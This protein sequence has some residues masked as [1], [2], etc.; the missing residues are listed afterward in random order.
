MPDPRLPRGAL[1]RL[2]FLAVLG[3]TLL[4]PWS[5]RADETH[6]CPLTYAAAREIGVA[7]HDTEAEIVFHDYADAAALVREF[8]AMPP[9]SEWQADHVL[10]MDGDDDVRVALA[11]DGCVFVAFRVPKSAWDELRRKALGEGA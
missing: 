8:N 10:V 9:V 11:K 4:V 5:A 1:L 2:G 3:S 7:V 6:G